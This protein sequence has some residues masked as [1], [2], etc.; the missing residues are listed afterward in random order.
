M[1]GELTRGRGFNPRAREGRDPARSGPHRGDA[2]SIHAP[3]KGATSP[4]M[5]KSRLTR[6]FNPRAR[7]GRDTSPCLMLPIDSSFQSTRP[8]RARHSRYF[9]VDRSQMFQSTRPR[10]ARRSP[11]PYLTSGLIVSIHA[12]AKGAT[13]SRRTPSIPLRVS[14]HAPA[15]G[16]TPSPPPR[17]FQ[18]V[19]VSI[20]APAKGATHALMPIFSD[21]CFNPRA[22]EG[23]DVGPYRLDLAQGVSIHAPA[24]G[25]TWR[26]IP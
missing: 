25:A 9:I 21:T 8:R 5:R 13:S 7:E 10:R 4:R 26:R 18:T 24:K 17:T 23:R 3:A 19:I 15:K 1:R 6:R 20:H 16:A 12:P 11:R 14:I 22:R 2:V